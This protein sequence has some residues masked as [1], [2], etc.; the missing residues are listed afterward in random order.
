M[1]SITIHN[2]DE[3]LAKLIKSKARSE[4]MSVNKT[5]KKIL[6]TSFGIKPRGSDAKRADFEEF[7]GMWSENDLAEFEERT[8]EFRKIDSGDWS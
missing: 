6:E 4:S 8:K 1:K 7:C 3:P 2:I 5:I